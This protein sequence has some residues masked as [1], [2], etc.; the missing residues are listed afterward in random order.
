MLILCGPVLKLTETFKFLD[1][2]HA[3]ALGAYHKVSLTRWNDKGSKSFTLADPS[4]NALS[5]VKTVHKATVH[6]PCRA[7][8]KIKMYVEES[9]IYGN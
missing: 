9:V 2:G 1:E 3:P 8:T 5:K 7:Q 6:W 4:N